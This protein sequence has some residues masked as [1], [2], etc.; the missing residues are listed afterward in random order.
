MIE[1]KQTHNQENYTVGSPEW[2]QVYQFS[3][4]SG[5]GMTLVES[6]IYNNETFAFM[7]GFTVNSLH[8]VLKTFKLPFDG[9]LYIALT[10]YSVVASTVGE[11]DLLDCPKEN[12]SVCQA[13][14]NLL[15]ESIDK[16]R[17]EELFDSLTHDRNTTVIE[18]DDAT[19]LV[20]SK[21]DLTIAPYSYYKYQVQGIEGV[22]VQVYTNEYLEYK[23]AALYGTIGIS[24]LFLCIG[25]F[26][27]V[28]QKYNPKNNKTNNKNQFSTTIW[29]TT[30]T[31]TSKLKNQKQNKQVLQ[32][33]YLFHEVM[34][35]YLK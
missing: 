32:L 35:K 19:I 3:G 11:I 24:I 7:V 4:N 9:L 6:V 12:A 14:D 30:A 28:L 25:M 29:S 33:K 21:F 23:T 20:L 8:S 5:F 10:D 15:V 26:V 22:S 1:K 27:F 17:D 16:I 2:T 13:T 34:P 18:W 31:K